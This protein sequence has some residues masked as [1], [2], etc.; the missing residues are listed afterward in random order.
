MK[1]N[2]GRKRSASAIASNSDSDECLCDI[3]DAALSR[4]TTTR[5]AR[6]SWHQ[7]GPETLFG[8]IG[9]VADH[10]ASFMD[11]GFDNGLNVQENLLNILM[12]GIVITSCYSGLGAFEMAV[13]WYVTLVLA[14]V[15]PETDCSDCVVFCS[16]CDSGKLQRKAIMGCIDKIRPRHLFGTLFE[17]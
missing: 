14:K 4:D 10:I 11:F 5:R 8:T 9:L 16:A 3:D 6:S 13:Y 15:A 1:S 12:T 17:R 2:H 7:P